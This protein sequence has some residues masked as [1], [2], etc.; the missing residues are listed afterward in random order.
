MFYIASFVP[1]LFSSLKSSG[2]HANSDMR[3]SY[4]KD[5]IDYFITV[6]L[7]IIPVMINIPDFFN[8]FDFFSKFALRSILTGFRCHHGCFIDFTSRTSPMPISARNSIILMST[9]YI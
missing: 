7:G 9:F 4:L 1:C 2:Y 8:I 3:F 5:F 6:L